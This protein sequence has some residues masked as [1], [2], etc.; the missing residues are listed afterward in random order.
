MIGIRDTSNLGVLQLSLIPEG[1]FRR[2]GAV[3]CP[4]D[5]R[6]RLYDRRHR[7]LGPGYK[8]VGG[9]ASDPLGVSRN[10]GNHVLAKLALEERSYGFNS[11]HGL[12][13][14]CFSTYP[15]HHT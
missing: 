6:S 11:H 8:Y 3:G 14:Y 9:N 5:S 13:K 7:G 12:F 1:E 2:R 10:G 15:V 4:S